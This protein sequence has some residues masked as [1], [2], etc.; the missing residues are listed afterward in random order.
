M[1]VEYSKEYIEK[2]K[3]YPQRLLF[4]PLTMIVENGDTKH[5]FTVCDGKVLLTEGE[6]K[7]KAA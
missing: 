1:T 3:D 2:Q 5:V 6:R 4:R 7:T